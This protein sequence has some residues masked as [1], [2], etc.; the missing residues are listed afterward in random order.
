MVELSTKYMGMD[1]RNPLI[2]ASSGLVNSLEGVEKCAESGAGAV[3]LKSLFEEQIEA[4]TKELMEH[5]WLNGHTEA[6][7]YVRGMG[8]SLGPSDYLKLIEDVKKKVTIPV[9]ASLNCVSA[10]WWVDYAKQIENTG[11]DA[12]ELNIS[13]MPSDPNRVSEEIEKQ[14]YD[15]VEGV[16][17][18][19][20]IPIAVKIGPFFTSIARMAR[21][22]Y[23]RGVSA[24]VLFNRFYQLDI[25]VDSIKLVGGNPL[26]SPKEMNLPL[27]WIA[28]LSGRIECDFAASTGV[29][30]GIDAIKMI[31]AGAKAVQICSV[32]Y[33]NG[34]EQIGR[35]QKE[36]E[37]WMKGHN[38]ESLSDF[39]GIL[40]Q[41]ESDKSELYERLQY[42]KALSGK[43]D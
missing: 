23:R 19:I 1:L 35:V 9:I 3:V 27:R 42:I 36:M 15:I 39:R 34:V 37:D 43:K 31:L 32:L 4:D 10:K 7:D 29:H 8:M 2:V 24:L 11:A 17:R 14:Y 38:F 33:Q 22:L 41:E 12:L 5:I 26:S 20:N 21:E 25:D 28:L 18:H 6:F 16:R 13:V 30:N 40:S